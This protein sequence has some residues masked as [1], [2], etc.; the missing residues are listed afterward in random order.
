M[1]QMPEQSRAWIADQKWFHSIDFGNGL[2][3]PARFPGRPANF[4]L[5]GAQHFL[6][7]ID[8]TGK[9]CLDIGTVDGL[10]A[11][12]LKAQ[13][14]GHVVASDIVR[15]PTFEFGRDLLELD[16][17]Y[18]VPAKIDNMADCLGDERFD[19]IVNAGILYHLIDPVGGLLKCRQLLKPGGLM[20]METVHLVD[21]GRNCMNFCPNANTFWKTDLENFYWIPSLGAIEGMLELASFE[22]LGYAAS[23]ERVSVLARAI[24]PSRTRS[25]GK[26]V[27]GL[28]RKGKQMRGYDESLFL[29]AFENDSTE[30]S[31]IKYQVED[32]DHWIYPT[33]HRTFLPFQPDNDHLDG[34]AL[35]K[36]RLID[37]GMHVLY[38]KA[39]IEATVRNRLFQ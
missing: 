8:V 23:N 5:Y 20:I 3:S 14:A 34:A 12:M 1:M 32:Y 10:T 33:R 9:S 39:R 15:R 26:M 16:I 38:R 22:V 4:S 6:E 21:Q 37:L 17:D 2:K 30:P 29:E 27:S 31:T 25:R 28:L 24:K 35:W 7:K 13:G 36:N 18:Q 11:F 19:L